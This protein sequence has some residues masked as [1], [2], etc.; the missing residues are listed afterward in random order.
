MR[1]CNFVTIFTDTTIKGTFFNTDDSRYLSYCH[2]LTIINVF[3]NSRCIISLLF[4]GSPSTIPRLVIPIVIH[5]FDRMFISGT[6]THI[7]KKIRKT[8]LPTF[9]NRYTSS[10]ISMPFRGVLVIAALFHSF[11]YRILTRLFSVLSYARCVSCFTNILCT[12]TTTRLN[13]TRE[14]MISSYLFYYSATALKIPITTFYSFDIGEFT[15]FFTRK[16]LS[17]TNH[18]IYYNTQ[19]PEGWQ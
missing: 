2:K 10:P 12:F 19:I 1:H 15:S 5:S 4:S 17:F 9:T 14:N 16:V 11:P 13:S 18:N 6:T 7:I 3:K 8:S